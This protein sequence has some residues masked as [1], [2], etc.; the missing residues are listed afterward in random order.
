MLHRMAKYALN[1]CLF[2]NSTDLVFSRNAPSH[3]LYM[4]AVSMLVSMTRRLPSHVSPPQIA[5]QRATGH[6]SRHNLPSARPRKTGWKLNW[7]FATALNVGFDPSPLQTEDQWSPVVLQMKAIRRFVITEKAP[8]R[9]FSWL[10]APTSPFTFK[11]LLREG[12]KKKK[13]G[14][15]HTLADPP[16]LKYGK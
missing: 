8:T 5:E 1:I 2:M 13:Y 10:K 7:Y 3:S 4:L 16:T 6:W 14:N 12:F 15:F 9:A 11:T